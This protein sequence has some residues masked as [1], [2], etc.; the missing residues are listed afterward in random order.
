MSRVDVFVPCYNY[1]RFLRECVESILAQPVDVRVLIIDD[2][3]TD[4][5]PEVAADLAAR[6]GRVDIRR[7]RDNHGHIATYNEGLDWVTADYS[8]LLSAD[9]VLTPGALLRA[10]NLL[11]AHPDV[12]FVYGGVI[13]FSS[14]NAPVDS[15]RPSDSEERMVLPGREWL[16]AI[17][18]EGDNL[19]T[20]PEVVVRSE[21][22]R[23]LGGYRADLPHTADMEMW[24][25]L[26][27]HGSVGILQAEQAYYRIHGSNMS[28]EH[29]ERVGLS[30]VRARRTDY[31]ERK[32]AYESF[33][34][35]EGSAIAEAAS[36][37]RSAEVGLAWNAFWRA[38]QAFD[39]GDMANFEELLDFAQAQLPEISDTREWARL[40]WKKLIGHKAWFLIRSL[41]RPVRT[42][43]ARLSSRAV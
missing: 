2:A 20:A 28:E 5:T 11:D 38:Y 27:A 37:Q 39:R 16:Q 18:S 33:F 29:L 26:A 6:D 9:D 34:R 1:G 17:C 8:Q 19:I 31:L 22:Q 35:S 30:L 4:E 13:R 24:M 14:R 40:R 42:T 10:R 32:A 3:S 43:S 12:G 21:L 23:R 25:R 15:T 7:H 36:L 41:V